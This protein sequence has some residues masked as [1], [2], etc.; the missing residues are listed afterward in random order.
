MTKIPKQYKKGRINF[1][2]CKIDLSQRVFIPR[3][4]TEYWVKKAIKEI[5]E[6]KVQDK[7]IK[8][9]DIFSGSGCIGIALLKHIPSSVIDFV[10]STE[11]AVRQIKINLGL[12][13]ISNDR[14]NVYLSDVFSKLKDKDY[15]FILSNPPYV[16]EGRIDEVDK[17]VLDYEPREAL[18]AGKKGLYYIQKL[19][20]EAK[21]FLKKEGVLYIEFD[22][23]QKNDI[24]KLLKDEGYKEFSFYRDQFQKFRWLK[25]IK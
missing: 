15:H 3:P 5:L 6:S 17:S 18:F 8:M 23:Q 21:N 19:I 1:L 7:E 20:S 4:E 25:A 16:A 14:C 13:K 22:P 24:K 12:N 9:L 11:K 10:D 2:G